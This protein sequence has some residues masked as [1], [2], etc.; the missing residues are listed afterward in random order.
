MDKLA[1]L[2]QIVQERQAMKVTVNDNGKNRK[3][4]IDTFSANIALKTIRAV[5]EANR[6]KLLAMPITKMI[7]V[8]VSVAA[9]TAA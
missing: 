8:C 7:G 5:N 1:I 3:V 6:K 9:K 4:L 2:E